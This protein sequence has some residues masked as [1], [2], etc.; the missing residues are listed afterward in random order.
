MKPNDDVK[1]IKIEAM[2][3]ITSAMN[4]IEKKGEGVYVKA[5]S[6]GSLEALLEFLKNP[7]VNIPFS[8]ISIGP[9]DEKDAK[10]GASCLGRREN[11]LPFWLLMSRS[12]WK[13]GNLQ[14]NWVSNCSA[15]MLFISCLIS[16]SLILII[17][18]RRSRRELPEMQHSPVFLRP[19]QTP[20]SKRRIPFF[21]GWTS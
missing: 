9:V 17:S 3:D 21:W 8:I 4:R 19:Y 12:R 5:A 11:M 15:Q 2:E 7:A 16:L 14:I 1:R 10:K 18:R 13:F 6:L 20:F